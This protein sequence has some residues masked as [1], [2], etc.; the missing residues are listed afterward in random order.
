MILGLGI[1][2]LKFPSG[3]ASWAL[4]LHN[5][6]KIQKYPEDVYPL[7]VE[8]LHPNTTSQY[9]SYSQTFRQLLNTKIHVVRWSWEMACDFPFRCKTLT[10]FGKFPMHCG[11]NIMEIN[12]LTFTTLNLN[13]HFLYI[14]KTLSVSL[15]YPTNILHS[16]HTY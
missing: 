4:A 8:F 3:H 7:F 14:L 10:I 11:Y 2:L 6:M 5:S 9:F 12:M 16:K 15:S 13:I 1:P